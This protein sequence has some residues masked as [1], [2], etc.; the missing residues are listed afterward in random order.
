MIRGVRGAITVSGNTEDEIIS[1]TEELIKEIIDSNQ[2][3]PTSVA[4]VFISTTEDLD[5]TFPA[6]ALRKF[7]SWTY[8]PVMCMRE[9]PVQN[10]LKNC[11]RIMMHV[12]TEKL[13][14]E[15][16]HIYLRDAK[17][18]RPDL[19]NIKEL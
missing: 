2:I 9:V 11:V 10:S 6:K 19:G 3:H 8:V 4:S 18:L 5:A 16:N 15:I 14:E 17:V 12:N 13:Q 7:A 1:A